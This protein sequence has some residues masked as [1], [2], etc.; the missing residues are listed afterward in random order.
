M[1]QTLG[2]KKAG[3]NFWLEAQAPTG[4]PYTLQASENL[5]LWVDIQEDVGE[6][7]TFAIESAGHTARYFRLTP[8]VTSADPIRIVLLGD[9]LVAECCGWGGGL[10]TYFKPNAA[11]INYSQPSMST[12]YFLKSAEWDR[13]RLLKPEYVLMQFAWSECC[14]NPERSTSNEEYVE[15]LRLIFQTIRDFNGVPVFITL[16]ASRIWDEQGKLIDSRTH[17]DFLAM[18]VAAEFGTP[19]VDLYPL[20]WNLFNQLGEDGVAFMEFAP[21]DPL[22]LTN[23]GA[24][25]VSRLIAQNLP[26]RLGPYM[27]KIFDAPPKP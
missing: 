5:H 21:D 11:V 3:T 4:V 22:H 14:N 16:H 26:D 15:N 23:L 8:L 7:Q 27:T 1:G 25:W 2:F 12:K 19:V 20:T 17:R 18:G 6:L 10:P 13:L 9:S 24:V